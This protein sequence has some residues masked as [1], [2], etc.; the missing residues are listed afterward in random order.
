MSKVGLC[1]EGPAFYPNGPVKTGLLAIS[2]GPEKGWGRL[3]V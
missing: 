2:Y 1:K 3:A